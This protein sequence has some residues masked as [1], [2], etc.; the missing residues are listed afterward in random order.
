ML[1][2]HDSLNPILISAYED[3][4]ELVVVETKIG[5]KYIRSITGY[6]PQETWEES[7]KLPFFIALDKEIGKAQLE[8]K[9]V[10]VSMDANSKLGPQYIP[11]DLHNMS[12]TKR[13]LLKLWKKMH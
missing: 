7:E 13:Y 10:F 3:E 6:G 11:G 2:I 5:Q 8:N 12:K 1:G 9:S 4:F